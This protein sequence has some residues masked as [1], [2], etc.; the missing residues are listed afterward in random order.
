MKT[1]TG[2]K[3]HPYETTIEI[4]RR[5]FLLCF[6]ILVIAY[7]YTIYAGL[8]NRELYT[9]LLRED[10]PLE[11][12]ATACVLLAAILFFLAYFRYRHSHNVFFLLFSMALFLLFMEEISWG[13]RI[14]DVETPRIFKQ[15]NAQKEIN[16]HNFTPIYNYVN[17]VAYMCFEFYMVG[18]P[19]LIL[20][21][22]NFHKYLVRYRV[23]VPSPATAF[24]TFINYV[25]YRYFFK[26]LLLYH[27][28][29]GRGEI[30]FGEIMETG[31]EIIFLYFSY[32]CYSRGTTWLKKECN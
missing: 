15:I 1:T 20:I 28:S 4:P 7:S 22:H 6:L 8:S 30:N 17:G 25:L 19:L 10:G 5:S 32:E 3:S 13:Q 9:F 11:N 29:L 26:G 23:P 31:I 18:V 2:P 14:F 21:Y 12:I 24:L 16:L 27:G